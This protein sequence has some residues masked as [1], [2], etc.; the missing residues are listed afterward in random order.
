V[1]KGTK[2]ERFTPRAMGRASPKFN[3]LVHFELVAME[4]RIQ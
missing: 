3:T 1:H 2:I 4:G